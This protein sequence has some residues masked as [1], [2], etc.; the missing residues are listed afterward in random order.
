MEVSATTPF[1]LGCGEWISEIPEIDDSP[2]YYCFFCTPKKQPM[3]IKRS[4]VSRD[5]YLR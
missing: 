1:C 5:F 4:K 3:K 2:F